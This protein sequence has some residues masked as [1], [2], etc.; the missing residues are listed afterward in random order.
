VRR[1][2]TGQ[3][4]ALA[5]LALVAGGCLGSGSSTN[6]GRESAPAFVTRV[7]E[8]FSRG[9]SGR[10]WDSLARRDQ[11]VVSRA[12]YM[13]CTRNEGWDLRSVKV[14]E[15]YKEPVDV[16]GA[17]ESSDAVTVRVTSSN[18]ITTATLH[19]IPSGT[20]WRWILPAADRAAYA[21][22]RCP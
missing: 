8:E 11:A 12:R 18:G 2:R 7:T 14:L 22:G 1:R 13:A 16:G 4:A 17:S 21:A 20:G 5:A 10:L 9:Q 6:G 3:I 19:A 15:T